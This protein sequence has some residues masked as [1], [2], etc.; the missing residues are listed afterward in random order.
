MNNFQNN[1]IRMTRLQYD[2]YIQSWYY[3][4]NKCHQLQRPA[5]SKIFNCMFCDDSLMCINEAIARGIVVVSH[6]V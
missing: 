2:T 6:E 3:V 1:Y 4:C 5:N